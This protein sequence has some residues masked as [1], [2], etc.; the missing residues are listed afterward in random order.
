MSVSRCAS[1]CHFEKVLPPDLVTAAGLSR[2]IWRQSHHGPVA[3]LV[4]ARDGAGRTPADE[5]GR[6]P[7]ARRRDPGRSLVDPGHGVG[8]DEHRAFRRVGPSLP[9][10]ASAPRRRGD[11]GQPRRPQSA[12]GPG[13]IERAGATVRFLPSYS[14]DFNPIEAVWALM[15]QRIRTVA[16]RTDPALRCTAQ[17]ARRVVRPRHGRNWFA[18]AGYQLQ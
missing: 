5:L 16:P 2:R 6:Q 17:R 7:D 4:A 12:S 15:K 8:G 18:H 13:P 9:R 11:H 3:R 1:S 10:A 14:H